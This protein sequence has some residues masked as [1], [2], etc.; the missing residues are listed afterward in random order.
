MIPLL[1]LGVLSS[2]SDPPR[3]RN[4]LRRHQLTDRFKN[5]TKLF[6]VFLLQ[7]VKTSSEVGVSREHR[8]EAHESPHNGNVR[9]DG[10]FGRASGK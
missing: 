3:G 8:S 7:F 2:E 4:G 10:A 6:V 1:C 5:D 9:F